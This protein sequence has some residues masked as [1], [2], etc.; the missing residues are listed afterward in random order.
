MKSSGLRPMSISA[1]I[2]KQKHK[3]PQALH[4]KLWVIDVACEDTV[5]RGAEN[6]CVVAD[7]HMLDSA[8]DSAV[9]VCFK[10][11]ERTED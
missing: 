11:D 6:G 8:R 1:L 4:Q 7:N 10:E 9:L 3:E 5:G 2:E